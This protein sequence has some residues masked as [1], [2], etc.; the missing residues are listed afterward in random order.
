MVNVVKHRRSSSTG[1]T[2][3]SSDLEV[4]EIALNTADAK[5][6]IK[7][8]D[9]IVYE[10][11]GGGAGSLSAMTDT[12]ITSPG[13]GEL[14]VYDTTSSK[15]INQTLAEAGIAPVA[16]P[17]LTG[18]P[19]AP[20]A[21]AATNSTQIA[22]TA[23]VTTAVS[24]LVD[25][26][27]GALN[28]L[29]ELAAAL[30]DDASFSTTVTNSI[31]TKL[32]LA[33]G[34]MT[35]HLY[36]NGG[37]ARLNDAD[38]SPL[39]QQNS[40]ATYVGSTGRSTLR[41]ATSASGNLYHRDLSTDYTIFTDNYH[42]NADKW[43]TARTLSLTGDVTGSVSWDGSGNAS[44]A[45]TVGNDSHTHVFG[46]ITST[47]LSSSSNLDGYTVRALAHWGGSNPANSPAAYGAMFV[48]PDG[49]QP[50]QIVQ[51]YGGAA[52]KV[53]LYGRRKT[54]GT[55]DTSWTQYFS[56]HYHPNADTLTT[57]RTI[58][59][60]SFNG[61][62]NITVADS[63]KLPLSGGTMTG[64]LTINEDGDSINLRSTTN[65]TKVGISFSSHYP[66]PS[67]IGHIR[68]QHSDTGS[69]GSGALL[70]LGSSE[71]STTIL[72]DGK[73]MY[74][75]GIYSKP[76]SGTG[77]GT[78]KD[79]NWDTAYTT[80]N[81]ALPKAGGT[82]TGQLIIDQGEANPLELKRSSQVGIEFNDT[83][84]TPRYLG[85][86]GGNLY[87]G[88]NLNHALNGRVFHDGYHPN[89]DKWTTARTLSL[90]GDASGSVS[91]DGSANATLS[92]T[93]A[94][95]SHSHSNYITSNADDTGTSSYSTTGT[96]WEIGDGTGSVAMTTNDGYGNANI[97]FNHR[98]G[99]P[100]VNGAACRIE[101]NVDSSA[102]GQ[103][104]FEVSSGAVTAGSAV[105][106]TEA[107]Y[108]G[109]NYADFPRFIRH[110][111][112]TDTYLEFNAANSLSV[113]TG[114]STRLATNADGII[115]N[116]GTVLGT[117][118]LTAD[119]QSDVLLFS[120]GHS[121]GVAQAGAFHN[122][123][124]L[125]GGSGQSRD[126]QLWQQDSE[127]VHIGTSYSSNQLH[128]DDSF[129]L[130]E[131]HNRVII[132]TDNQ[133]DG[134][135]RIENNVTDTNNDFYFAQE[136]IQTLSGSQAATGDREQGGIYMDINSTNTGGDTSQ[137][138]RAYGI[139]LDMDSTGDADYV[140]GIYSNVAAT[141]TTGTTSNVWAGYF[142]AEDNGG[143]GSV[144]NVH[145]IQSFAYS[146]NS[147]SDTDAMYAGYFKV[148]NAGDSAAIG[149]AHGVYSE[150]EI[151]TGSGDIYGN[152]YV[153]RAE[154][155]NNAGAQSNSTYL[156]YGNYAGTLP[157][158]AWGVYIVDTVDN[159]FAGSLQVG[160]KI[161]HAGDTDTYFQFHG[162]NLARMV[163]AGAEVQEW[164]ANYTLFSDSDQVR[165]GSSSDFR[166][167]FDGTNMN[168]RNYAHAGGNIYF[169]GEDTEG[170]NHALLYMMNDVSAPYLKL[171]QN[172]GE[173]LRTL[174]G[175]VGVTGLTV[176]DVDASPH[177]A[178]GLQV[179]S[180]SNEKI[181]L[182][183]TTSPYIRWQENTTDKAYIQWNT[184]GML[185]FF[186]QESANFRFRSYAATSAVN[187]R[188]EASDGDL[189][190][191]VYG[192]HDNSIGFLDDQ[193]E[194]LYKATRDSSHEW[195]IN[196]VAEMSLSTSTLD[197][198]NN[199]IDNVSSIAIGSEVIL[200]ESTDRADLLQI[201][202]STSSWGGLQ[203]RNSSN[204]GRW[205][206]MT[207]GAEAGIY[208]DENNKW[209]IHFT[210][211]GTT[212]FY[213]GGIE[214]VTIGSTYFEMSQHLDLNNYDIY[215]C[216]QIFHHGDTNTY[217]Q[218]HAADQW[219]VVVG[220][221]ER[222]EVKN[223]SPHVLVS[224]D[225]NSTSD[226]RLKKN[227]KP[228]DNALTDI[229]QL[230]G[231]TFDWKDTGTQGQGFIAQQVE[232]IIPDVV[233]TDE[234]TGM[235]SINYVG[236]IG[237]LVEAIKTQQTQIDDLKAEIQS[238]KS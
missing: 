53:S 149:S 14:L 155:D 157:S 148:Y 93:V 176:G 165:L 49:S 81:A 211:L 178:G 213:Y 127:Y 19:T 27:P 128:F 118:T 65:A 207:N 2:P 102:A 106:L 98:S 80:A 173:R 37:T 232:P 222:L 186:N 195:R 46:N 59:G 229:C 38:G 174:S 133:V 220:G 100:D 17:G 184:D 54:N 237:H 151:T 74:G 25:S 135:L 79:A 231:V 221:S 130:F 20:T 58:N 84:A 198:K 129:S 215:G 233:N 11:S 167:Y 5:L 163:L 210:E 109:S 170:S 22:T 50:Q 206:F 208:D 154:L 23:Y 71:S 96:Y 78:R 75:A 160:D 92:V 110:M 67:Q 10:I 216:D 40:G 105:A 12:T 66:T 7:H 124:R 153:Y 219:R 16:S 24:N 77:A 63:T 121:S 32:P 87:F 117:R 70:E 90:S 56:D 182:S 141:P 144:S 236:L 136:I 227:I 123:L 197:M 57:A 150:V 64:D 203:I 83:S 116:D 230:E 225:L 199:A 42:P 146:D 205:S 180:A 34:T 134:A 85:V 190:G 120:T 45:A 18:T 138:H 112:D 97:A 159:Y 35:G 47:S 36:L 212:K 114:G 115:V 164:G 209:G 132:D 28:T 29:N 68:F 217:M 122:K 223:S 238:M 162:E 33:G 226:E 43:T 166:M 172:G 228:I 107:M 189:Y 89:A 99:V 30:G 62:A 60:V 48:I 140:M 3:S 214:K 194:W 161:A 21:S 171:H 126:L 55:W 234:D 179:V 108:L 156:Y 1:E 125:F 192:N 201:T 15:W 26:A 4:G 131:F 137:E 191:S 224:G 145:G 158:T 147:N 139:Y 193:G 152:T 143:A 101:T 202:S 196:N 218:F 86:N 88:G 72:A 6:F 177:N 235:K 82:M 103:F 119:F 52:N 188:L 8:T 204:E 94:N 187:I 200:A 169:Q 61:S 51:T 41:L 95:D 183:G 113:V 168:F 39:I 9:G 142:W 76:A 44:L 185:G 175:G 31:A 73:L 181:V 104:T 91:W 111:G 13:D 69:Y